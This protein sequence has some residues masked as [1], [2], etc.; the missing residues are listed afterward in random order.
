MEAA[1]AELHI[2]GYAHSVETW[3]EGRLVGGLYGVSIG[4]AFFG[5]SM[6]SLVSYASRAAFNALCSF[7]WARGF[8][9]IDGQFPNDNLDTL[10]AAVISRSEFLSRLS[11]ALKEPTLKGK[12]DAT[13][14]PLL[15]NH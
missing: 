2:Q 1:Y 11:I 9:F 7:A 6:F 10:G 5:E 12:W 13:P 8:H 3:L 14:Y 4:A 15:T